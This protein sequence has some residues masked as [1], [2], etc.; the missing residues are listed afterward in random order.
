MFTAW[1]VQEGGSLAVPGVP[2]LDTI[3]AIA[4][5]V[6]EGGIGIIKISGPNARS[7]AQAIFHARQSE[8]PLQSHR[9]HY[10]WIWNPATREPIDEVLL[11]YMAGPHTYTC[12]DVVEINCHSGFAVLQRIMEL[13][14]ATGARLAEP[15]EFTRRAFLNGRIGLSQAE[16]V[17]E[18]IRSRSQQSLTLAGRHLRGEFQRHLETW[19]EQLLALRATM[20]AS[21]DFSHDTTDEPEL[22]CN[23]LADLIEENLLRPLNAVLIHYESGRILR[24]GLTLVLVGKPNVGKSSLLN[25]LLGKDRAIVSPFPGTT[26]DVIE[27]G[28]VLGGIFVR[29]LDTAGIREQPDAIEVQGIER[30]LRSLHEADAALWVVD[31]SRPLSIEDDSIFQSLSERRHIIILNKADLPQ[32]TNVATL[33]SRYGENSAIL[34]ISALN[35]PDIETLRVSLRATFLQQPLASSS[36]AIIP[37]L[38]QKACLEDAHGALTR[39]VQLL[40]NDDFP[41][42]AALEFKA[43]QEQLDLLLGSTADEELLDRVFSEFCIGK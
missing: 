41:E 14:L 10:G 22:S 34:G 7:I 3:C 39:A 21:I 32:V 4:T 11:S 6:G 27:D 37:N 33:T 20:E 2:A 30:T 36:S 16:A 8:R 28:F 24:E 35:P 29:I 31:Q 18:L 12:E 9:L 5:P 19:R 13:V 40:R 25:A 17:I 15:G 23:S 26:R 1:R 43:A 42:L 38:R